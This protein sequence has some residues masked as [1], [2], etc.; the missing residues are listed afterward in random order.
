MNSY[1]FEIWA[2]EVVA[3]YASTFELSFKERKSNKWG[4]TSYYRRVIWINKTKFMEMRPDHRFIHFKQTLLHE[5]AHAR[6]GLRGRMHHGKDW[7][8]ECVNLGI[9]PERFHPAHK[10]IVSHYK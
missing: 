2:K 6:I 8:A 4:T 5:V 1:L 3:Y 9:L 7:K 10:K